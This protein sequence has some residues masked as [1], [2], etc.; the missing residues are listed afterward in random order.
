MRYRQ[1]LIVH[2]RQWELH[3]AAANVGII[4]DVTA[5]GGPDG[6]LRIVFRIFFALLLL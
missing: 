2:R 5:I 4:L 6:I 3:S 1:G